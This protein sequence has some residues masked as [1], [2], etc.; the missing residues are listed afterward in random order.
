MF[1]LERLV[2]HAM[3]LGSGA[4]TMKPTLLFDK[5]GELPRSVCTPVPSFAGTKFTSVSLSSLTL[6]CQNPP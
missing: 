4:P 3:C 5:Y 1:K 2:S 6:L